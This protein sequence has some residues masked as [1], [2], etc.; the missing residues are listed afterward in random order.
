MVHGFRVLDN[1]IVAKGVARM[2]C[3][4]TVAGTIRPG[5][6]VNL[7]VPGDGSHL[8]R[9]PLSFSH[10]DAN[11]LLIEFVFGIVGEGTRRLSGIA[12]GDESTLV[13]P[14]GRGW[15]LP[16]NGQRCLLVAGGKIGRAHV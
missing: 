14:S 9:I 10:A 16:R 13:G 12:V 5:Q 4:S 8:L 1:E 2:V 15:W 11:N 7:E 3:H 6:F